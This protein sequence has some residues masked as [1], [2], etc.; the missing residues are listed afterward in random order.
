MMTREVN[1]ASPTSRIHETQQEILAVDVG[2]VSLVDHPAIEEEWLVIKA[3]TQPTQES[4][5]ANKEAAKAPEATPEVTPV[6]KAE[7]TPEVT[8]EVTPEATPE[9]TKDAD[10][11]KAAELFEQAALL[12]T[13]HQPKAEP[14][15][16]PEPEVEV[17]T[18]KALVSIEDGKLVISNELLDVAKSRKTFSAGRTEALKSA[19]KALMDVLKEVAPEAIAGIMG[20][21]PEAE[22]APVTKSIASPVVDV[23]E[24]I[25]QAVTKA[26]QPVTERLEKLEGI[27]VA[28][29]SGDG[30]QTAEVKKSNNESIWSGSALGDL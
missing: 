22:A 28:P 4:T 24:T 11:K 2:E 15:A 13:P 14:D 10:V 29:K 18:A 16:T 20:E 23:S 25:T 21:T 3:K 26:L 7:T 5:M 9:D 1:K 17:E 12:L 6:E 8:P 27:K 19:T 30:D